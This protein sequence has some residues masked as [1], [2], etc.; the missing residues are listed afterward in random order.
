MEDVVSAAAVQRAHLARFGTLA[1]VPLPL[2][3]VRWPDAAAGDHLRRL[4]PLLSSRAQRVVER[5]AAAGLGAVVYHYPNVP[6]R[7]A[8][9]PELLRDRPETG[10]LQ[11]LSTVVDPGATVDGWLD[12]VARLL[13]LGF[14]PGSVESIGVGHCLEMKN[15]VI[16]GGFVD[17]I[18]RAS[19]REGVCQYV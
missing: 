9:L 10:W 12:L 14:L 13:V 11:R 18:G 4:A 15:A 19:C 2:S 17:K 6:Q 5:V 7:V 8:H 1:R 3:A 16:D